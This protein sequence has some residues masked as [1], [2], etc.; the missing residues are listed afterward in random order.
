MVENQDRDI[1]T[2]FN[3]RPGDGWLF[4]SVGRDN[5]HIFTGPLRLDH[6]TAE[7]IGVAPRDEDAVRVTARLNRDE[8]KYDILIDKFGSW[9]P[10]AKIEMEQIG[11]KPFV[12]TVLPIP[13]PEPYE[14]EG[15][16]VTQRKFKVRAFRDSKRNN[17]LRFQLPE[18]LRAQRNSVSEQ[19]IPM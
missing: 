5:I 16:R 12:E 14:V 11:D 18:V 19:D 3:R 15:M 7:M 9:E 17:I 2:T 13:L 10:V 6:A 1:P 4:H 8:G